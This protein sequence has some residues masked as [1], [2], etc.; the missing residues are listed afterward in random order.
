M[1]KVKQCKTCPWRKDADPFDIPNGYSVELHEK[2]RGTIAKP[3]DVCG[4]RDDRHIM[5]CHYSEPGKEFACAGWLHHQLGVGNNIWLRL[6]LMNGSM[7]LP[8]IDGEQHE[9]FED[10]LP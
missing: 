2:L 10:T 5:A 4:M 6:A 8:E 1:E 7:P 9:T 3:G